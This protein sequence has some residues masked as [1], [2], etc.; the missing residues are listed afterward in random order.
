M[1]EDVVE[2]SLLMRREAVR[3]KMT[4]DDGEKSDSGSGSNPSNNT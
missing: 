3:R 4:N 2:T 1:E